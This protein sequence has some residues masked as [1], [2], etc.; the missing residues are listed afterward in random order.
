MGA[1]GDI[2]ETF[3]PV[4]KLVVDESRRH[5][6]AAPKGVGEL[7]YCGHNGARMPACRP[8]KFGKIQVM[9]TSISRR[10]TILYF[11]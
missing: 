10:S 9:I 1:R 6:L 3:S 2:P 4:R 5:V 7:S 8:N 11:N